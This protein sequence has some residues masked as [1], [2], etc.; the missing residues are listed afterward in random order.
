MCFNPFLLRLLMQTQSKEKTPG[1]WGHFE[2]HSEI[3]CLRTTNHGIATIETPENP[4]PNPII[5]NT[6]AHPG[7][8]EPSQFMPD[9]PG[10]VFLS[11]S[12]HISNMK[13]LLQAEEENDWN[14]LARL[15][16]EGNGVDF[17]RKSQGEYSIMWIEQRNPDIL[18][19][20]SM[21]K[22]VSVVSMGNA[23][24]FLIS[25]DGFVPK[26]LIL[27]MLKEGFECFHTQINI[28]QRSLEYEAIY[29]IRIGSPPIHYI[30][31]GRNHL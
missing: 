16:S 3:P 24:H 26:D 10:A 20:A 15:F 1:G 7:L 27:S 12:G 11:V 13:Y 8:K 28:I 21:H 14:L 29:K 30:G 23:S 6:M 9:T 25:T 22:L 17:L 2:P 4:G 19:V 18:F 5:M 31:V